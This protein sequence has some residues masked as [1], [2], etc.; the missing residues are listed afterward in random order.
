MDRLLV[1][2]LLGRVKGS[3]LD[4]TADYGG[5]PID[6]VT[7]LSP[8][9]QQIRSLKLKRA[10]PDQVQDMSVAISGTLPLLHTLEID[11]TGYFGNLHSLVAPTPPLFENA[12]NLSNFV[13]KIY[14]FPSLRHFTFPNL[15]TLYFST[16]ITP[17]PVSELLDFLEAS[18]ALRRISMLFGAV[19]FGKG[20]PQGR[21]IVLPCVETFHLDI[22]TYGPSCKIET[23]I[24]C[25]FAKCVEFVYRP[26]PVGDDVSG[27]IY[28]PSTSLGAIVN[29]Y[30]EGTVERVVLEV[31]K[32]EDF[33]V[34]CSI[35]FRSPDSATLE[36]CYYHYTRAEE[37]M[38]FS[39]ERLLRIFSGL[40]RQSEVTHYWPTSGIFA[41]EAAIS[42]HTTPSLLPKLLGNCWDPWDH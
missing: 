36:L 3:A 34:D 41:S 40:S 32:D 9:A 18:P 33:N 8:F 37:E 29:Q 4:I 20:V 27:D 24:S 31:M 2:T 30:T 42:S 23:H 39:E 28:P 1:K 5:L 11:A 25:P 15:T 26:E 14:K 13:L 6:D 21:I 7:L 35:T 12:T 16:W 17:Y 10:P 38:E 22:P 19:E